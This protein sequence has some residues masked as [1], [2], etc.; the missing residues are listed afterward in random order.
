MKESYPVEIAEY[1]E[2]MGISD[3]PAFSWW[4]PHV[5]KRRQ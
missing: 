2:A 3:K 5:L 4:T 1:V